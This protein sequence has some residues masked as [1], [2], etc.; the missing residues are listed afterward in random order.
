MTKAKTGMAAADALT[1]LTVS[2]AHNMCMC[3]PGRCEHVQLQLGP[4]EETG[5]C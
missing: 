4:P 5:S 2:H 1:A 3:L